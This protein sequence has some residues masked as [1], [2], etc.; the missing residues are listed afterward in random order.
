MASDGS[1]KIHLYEQPEHPESPYEQPKHRSLVLATLQLP[2]LYL[3]TLIMP[4]P[5]TFAREGEKATWR[6]VWMQLAFLMLIPAVLGLLKIFSR[7]PELKAMARSRA[8]YDIFSSFSV[9]TSLAVMGIQIL[10]A[11]I[12]FFVALT[13][14][15]LMAK[16]VRGHGSYLAQGYSMLLYHVPLALIGSI[17]SALFVIFNVANLHILSPLVSLLLFAYSVWLN[18]TMLTGIHSMARSKSTA[19]VFLYYLIWAVIGV[20]ALLIAANLIIAWLH[21]LNLQ[22]P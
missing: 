16:L 6:M 8:V 17:T 7:N 15:Y 12:L 22:Q 1:S 18:I 5:K 20:T 11:P 3:K 9:G 4:F 10:M 21:E 13:I 2:W 19:I 14:Q